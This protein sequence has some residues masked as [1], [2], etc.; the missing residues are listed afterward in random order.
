MIRDANVRAGLCTSLSMTGF[1]RGDALVLPLAVTLGAA[2]FLGERVGWRR[3]LAI[4]VGFAGVPL[5]EP[6]PLASRA[7]VQWRGHVPTDPLGHAVGVDADSG[8]WLAASRLRALARRRGAR[9]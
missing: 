9:S 5:K 3:R 1:A 6:V 8:P 4:L 7:S 2:P